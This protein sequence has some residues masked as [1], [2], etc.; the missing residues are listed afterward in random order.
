M[1]T[2]LGIP[3]GE[4]SQPRSPGEPFQG[5]QAWLDIGIALPGL[6]EHRETALGDP[7][8]QQ[9]GTFRNRLAEHRQDGANPD[10]LVGLSLMPREA[11]LPYGGPTRLRG[12]VVPGC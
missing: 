7:G 2:E 9:A 5:L 3:V 1:R 11:P 10:H 6:L 12:K 4:N 8:V